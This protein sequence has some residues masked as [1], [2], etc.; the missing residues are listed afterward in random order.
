MLVPAAELKMKGNSPLPRKNFLGSYL[1]KVSNCDLTVN[2]WLRK[3][4]FDTIKL[5]THHRIVNKIMISKMPVPRLLE[6]VL[7]D[8]DFW[9]N[10]S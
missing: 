7:K 5:T 4:I 2:V 1:V 10:P 3:C 6:K 9:S 8:F